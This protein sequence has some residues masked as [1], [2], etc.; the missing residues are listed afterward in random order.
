MSTFLDTFQGIKRVSP[1]IW[2]MRQAGRY[3]P[4]YRKI[5]K[6]CKSFLDLCY[7]PKLAT[8]VTLQPIQRFGFDAAIVFSDILVLPDAL[9]QKVTFVEGEGPK[10]APLDSFEHLSTKSFSQRLAPVYETVTAVRKALPENVPLIGFAGAPWTLA[11]YM[12]EGGG[13]RDFALAKSR[14]FLQV[15]EFEALLRLLEEAVT[16]HLLA[17]INAG[18]NAIQIFDTWAGLCPAPHFE[19]WILKPIKNITKAVRQSYPHIPLIGFPKGIGSQIQVFAEESGCSGLS[20]D[21]SI[22]PKE[23]AGVLPKNVVLQGNL[24]PVIL[25]AG[26]K[27]LEQAIHFIHQGMNDRPYIFN[28]GHGILPQTPIKNVEDCI[29]WV[30]SLKSQKEL[31]Y[32]S[33]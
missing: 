1:P 25:V 14:A 8:E 3:L 6:E 21:I 12:L 28:L 9:G 19:N 13:S 16:T 18:A 5:R 27:V 4:E 22:N 11:L 33:I 10:L 26:G 32:C 30:R 29:Q 20:L 31:S 7:S 2:F 24:D 23:A 17:Q 15:S